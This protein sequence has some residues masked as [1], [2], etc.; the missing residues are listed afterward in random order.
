MIRARIVAWKHKL[1]RLCSRSYR[2][3][4]ATVTRMHDL[5]TQATNA[6]IAAAKAGN[7]L[8]ELRAECRDLRDRLKLAISAQE[9]GAQQLIAERALRQ[10]ADERASQYHEQLT[11]ALMR[12]TD[13]FAMGTAAH[14]SMFGVGNALD[15]P[16]DKPERKPIPEKPMAR[17]VARK[18]TNATL[19][20]LL[21]E[22]RSG[23]IEPQAGPEFTTQ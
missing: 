2:E 22:I 10:S 9:S 11:D 7:E 3:H 20:Q 4:D 12:S 16:A 6:N 21:E 14:R 1:L 23:H 17:A 5:R 18:E 13:W 15:P 8:S 19:T